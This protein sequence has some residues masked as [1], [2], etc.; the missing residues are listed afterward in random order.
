M[1]APIP[2]GGG[3]GVRVVYDPAAINSE[4][5]G[6]NGMVLRE[7][8]RRGLRVETAAKRFAPADHG[9]LRG[10]ITH[11]VVRSSDPAGNPVPA[12]EVGT[13]VSYAAYVHRGTGIYGPYHTPIR[14]VHAQLLRWVDR[15]GT[16]MYARTVRG[17]RANPFLK[18]A[19]DREA[20]S[21]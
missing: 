13:D 6:A 14:P 2:A 20:G 12:V 11:R 19:L 15:R 10:S 21:G 17:Q 3:L 4:L 16:V 5:A 8:L 1:T 18:E 9:R 7:V